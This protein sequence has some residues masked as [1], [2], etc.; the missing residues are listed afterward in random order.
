MNKVSA[1]NTGLYT[2]FHQMSEGNNE[3]ENKTSQSLPVKTIERLKSNE[4]RQPR[5]NMAS[6]SPIDQYKYMANI[7]EYG[8]SKV[9]LKEIPGNPEATI[10]RA[11]LV[12]NSA[13]LP[14][15]L[16]NP[17]IEVLDE[18]FQLKRR[19]EARLDKVA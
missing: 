18:A 10:R 3:N 8:R 5:H 14:P 11:N 9:N 17:D 6:L 16:S 12:I 1:Y 15:M 13:A 7:G 19:M 2:G 4:L